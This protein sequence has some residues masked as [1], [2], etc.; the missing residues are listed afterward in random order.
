[1]RSV[2]GGCTISPKVTSRWSGLFDR[3]SDAVH[4]ARELARSNRSGLIAHGRD[5][6]IRD[7]D[8]YGRDPLP[9]R[10]FNHREKSTP[11]GYGSLSG[12]FLVRRD[13]D[14]SKPIYE[15]TE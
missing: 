6:R 13:I 3:K 8:H 11:K 10:E 15:Q 4:H 9:P 2:P 14:I 5:G 7:S 12:K 1:M